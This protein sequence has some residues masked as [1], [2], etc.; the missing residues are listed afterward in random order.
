MFIVLNIVF[1]VHV[2]VFKSWNNIINLS[3]QSSLKL[4]IL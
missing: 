2:G 1:S 4:F 3:V